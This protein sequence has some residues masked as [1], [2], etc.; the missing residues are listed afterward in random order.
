[1]SHLTMTTGG[2]LQG[3]AYKSK[4]IN[5]NFFIPESMKMIEPPSGSKTFSRAS[6]SFMKD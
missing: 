5:I 2:E 4:S 6:S 1:M 3:K